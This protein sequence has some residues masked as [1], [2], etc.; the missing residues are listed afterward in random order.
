MDK[1]TKNLIFPGVCTPNELGT[2]KFSIISMEE[3]I[4]DA[5]PAGVFGKRDAVPS[6]EALRAMTF[7][8]TSPEESV[9]A[10]VDQFTHGF[11]K[12]DGKH[13]VDREAAEHGIHKNNPAPGAKQ[14]SFPPRKVPIKGGDKGLVVTNLKFVRRE[15][16]T[17]VSLG[18]GRDITAKDV[19][20]LSCSSRVDVHRDERG[21]VEVDM[22]ASGEGECIEDLP[23]LGHTGHV[24]LE[25]NEG[26]V[27]IDRVAKLAVSRCPLD[28]PLEDI[29]HND[30]QIWVDRVPLAKAAAALEPAARGAI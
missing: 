9:S 12:E 27:G 22:K 8:T 7:L 18:E 3:L 1:P 21:F 6:N 28:E 16:E 4:P 20:H 25:E 24:T 26:V 29:G 10:A 11:R 13:I 30:K 15:G 14:L 5:K 19:D 17:E 23:E 2:I